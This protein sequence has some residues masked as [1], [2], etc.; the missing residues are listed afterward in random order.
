MNA[1]QKY[2]TL[3]TIFVFFHSCLCAD[4]S[5]NFQ[6]LDTH[7]SVLPKDTLQIKLGYLRINDTIDVLNIKQKE[8]GNLEEKYGSIGDMRGYEAE[9]RYGL[10]KKDTLFFHHQQWNVAY[11]STTLKNNRF[12]FFAR[13]LLHQN[14]F[15]TFNTLA[16][17]A[18][19]SY[20]KADD[21]YIANENLINA[22]IQ[23]IK[24]GTN[25]KIENGS[26]VYNDLKMTFYDKFTDK[27]IHPYIATTDMSDKTLFVRVLT[28]MQFERAILSLYMGA[29]RSQITSKVSIGPF[30][31][32]S[33]LDDQLKKFKPVSFDRYE[34]MINW[35]FAYGLVLGRKWLG[36]LGYEFDK[37]YR[38]KKLSA[39]DTNH[40]LKAS[41]TRAINRK[42]SFFAGGKI[43]LHQFNTDLPYLYNRYTQSRFDKKYGF[44]DVGLVYRF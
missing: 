14:A 44:I 30:G 23:K 18:G 10:T 36:E 26:I 25:A 39:I 2:I 31:R 40:I 5:F 16:I 38:G 20:D 37:F 9:V 11:S 42:L 7:A 12:A 3:S 24:P 6:F 34:T 43:M 35:G 33:F 15:T 29:K 22:T 19:V 8:I 4:S 41:L 28:G 27:K 13:H 32:N 21:L 1:L 17:D